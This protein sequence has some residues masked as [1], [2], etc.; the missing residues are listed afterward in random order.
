MSLS[1]PS[2][3]FSIYNEAVDNIWAKSV[4]FVYPE[5]T[6]E[7]PNCHFNGMKSNG[8]YKSGG[9][10]PFDDGSLCPYCNGEGLKLTE[11][12]DTTTARIYYN[13][14]DWTDVGFP[15]NIQNA[16][17]QIVFKMTDLPKVQ[18]AKY[19]IPEYYEGI[20]S[21][22]NQRLTRVGDYYPQGFTQNP[23]KYVITF[24]SANA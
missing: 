14:R 11:A 1:V 5:T 23:V 2:G 15:V 16:D 12:T 22:Q 20:E 17:A 19:I 6:E 21:Y 4:T 3:I 9:P 10:Y 24:W 13:R 18:K 7:C 8:V